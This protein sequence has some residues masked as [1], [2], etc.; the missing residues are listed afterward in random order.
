MF[1]LRGR[2]TSST[3]D[4][5]FYP[6]DSQWERKKLWREFWY[7]RELEVEAEYG[8]EEEPRQQLTKV[9]DREV[10]VNMPR[11]HSAPAELKAC[12]AATK[13]EIM[14]SPFNRVMDNLSRE[15]TEGMK[16]LQQL[17]K[18]QKIVIKKSYKA[19]GLVL[20]NILPYKETGESKM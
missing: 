10:K 14:G 2:Y 19:G 1:L 18:E 11:G 5:T 20:L 9:E 3:K 4:Q 8:E 16:E 17:Q 13:Y 7:N 15:E 12:I 6:P